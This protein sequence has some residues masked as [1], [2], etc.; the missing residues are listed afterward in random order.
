VLTGLLDAVVVAGGPM[1]YQDLAP[2]PVI[3][4]EAG[5]RL[6]DLSGGPLLS[7]PGTILVSNGHVHDDLLNLVAGLPHGERATGSGHRVSSA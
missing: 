7:G 6:T 2:L 5:G 1:G 4:N 3:L